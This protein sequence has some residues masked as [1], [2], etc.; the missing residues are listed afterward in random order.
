[1]LECIERYIIVGGQ[2]RWEYSIFL[3]GS[4]VLELELDPELDFDVAVFELPV[5]LDLGPPVLN[6]L[7]LPLMPDDDFPVEEEAIAIEIIL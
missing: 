6:T 2:V 5:V 1:M 3:S 4:V 7:S